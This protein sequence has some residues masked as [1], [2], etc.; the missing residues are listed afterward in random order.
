MGLMANFT[1]NKGNLLPFFTFRCCFT[2]V[3]PT[4]AE[5]EN[6][7]TTLRKNVLTLL[8]QLL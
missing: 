8:L 3:S 1:N 5:I 2:M 7:T 6:R 4:R